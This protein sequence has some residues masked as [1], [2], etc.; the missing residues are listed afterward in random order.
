VGDSANLC[1]IN[2]NKILIIKEDYKE[3]TMKLENW[4]DSF[5]HVKELLEDDYNHGQQFVVKTKNK[6]QDNTSVS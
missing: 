6:G 3:D 5:K 1:L 2:Y 4:G